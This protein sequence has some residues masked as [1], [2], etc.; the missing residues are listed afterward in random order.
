MEREPMGALS[1][2]ITRVQML[3]LELGQLSKVPLS[4]IEGYSEIPLEVIE[5]LGL[6]NVRIVQFLRIDRARIL[7]MPLHIQRIIQNFK[8]RVVK[9]IE[10]RLLELLSSLNEL[11]QKYSKSSP[12]VKG[13]SLQGGFPWGISVAVDFEF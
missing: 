11:K 2:D 7:E 5:E 4:R 1:E 8:S 6:E 12:H 13:F 10:D 9:E 3:N